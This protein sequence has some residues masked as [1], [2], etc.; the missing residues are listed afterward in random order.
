LP[1][2]RCCPRNPAARWTL[3][4]IG[5]EGGSGFTGVKLAPITS[6]LLML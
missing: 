4:E 5:L 2:Q 3:T 1:P 6:L